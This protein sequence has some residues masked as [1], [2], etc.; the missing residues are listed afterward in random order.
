MSVKVSLK[1]FQDRLP[2]LLDHRSLSSAERRELKSLLQEC[3][4]VMLR[5]AEALDH[6]A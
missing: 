5:R 6:I 4:V 3:D 2:E 1:Q